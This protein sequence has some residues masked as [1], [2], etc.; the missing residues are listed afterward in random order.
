MLG[1][2][3]QNMEPIKK[4]DSNNACIEIYDGYVIKRM[5]KNTNLEKIKWFELEAKILMEISSIDEI[6]VVNISEIQIDEKPFWYKMDRC[7][8]DSNALLDEMR[9]NP[10]IVAKL[11]LPIVRTL[12]YLAERNKPIYHRDIKPENILYQSNHGEIK[13]LLADFGCAFLDSGEMDRLTLDYRAVGARAFLAPEY[14]HGRV[15]SVNEKGDIFSLGKLF[16]YYVNGCENDVFPF[17]LWYT[18]EYDLI[19]R[20]PSSEKLLAITNIIASCVNHDPEKRSSYDKIIEGLEVILADNDSA[21]LSKNVMKALMFENRLKS[22]EDLSKQMTSNMLKSLEQDLASC[23]NDLRAKFRGVKIVYEIANSMHLFDTHVS[24]IHTICERHMNCSVLSYTGNNINFS[25]RI[26][27]SREAGQGVATGTK[28]PFIDIA[29]NSTNQLGIMKTIHINYFYS[30][31]FLSLS[32]DRVAFAH[33]QDYLKN[34]M[35]SIIDH[36]IE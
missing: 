22:N 7:Q 8:G 5:K 19:S 4:I 9:G 13:L 25:G 33:S 23:A 36:W 1:T 11:M 34:S 20:F 24:L 18:P 2:L 28:Y 30:D 10:K 12:K 16:W 35:T 21:E 15:E 6:S 17:T 29:L 26:H 3:R 32:V 14:H 31:D 27:P